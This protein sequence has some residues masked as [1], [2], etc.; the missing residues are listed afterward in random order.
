MGDHTEIRSSQFPYDMSAWGTEKAH[1]LL[2][3]LTELRD[4][5][6]CKDN[7]TVADLFH[8]AIWDGTKLLSFFAGAEWS[9]EIP[10]RVVKGGFAA[11]EELALEW[12]AIAERRA[13]R[14]RRLAD[15]TRLAT[16]ES[17]G[18]FA[19]A[20]ANLLSGPRSNQTTPFHR[21]AGFA[22]QR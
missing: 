22:G 12:G 20:K 9:Y 7:E 21:S 10:K 11:Y 15:G 17:L 4:L 19:A 3:A 5:C 1:N 16:K 8:A 13:D 6:Q 18:Q 14:M 2:E